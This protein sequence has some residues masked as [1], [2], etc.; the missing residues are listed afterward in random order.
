ML[1]LSQ[2]TGRLK[3]QVCSLAYELAATWRWPTFVQMTQSELSHI[4]HAVDSTINIVLGISI[5]NVSCRD[6]TREAKWNLVL[7]LACCSFAF[8]SSS[9]PSWRQSASG[10]MSDGAL[11]P[12]TLDVYA[13]C[14]D[15]KYRNPG[16]IHTYF[17]KCSLLSLRCFT[18]S[19]VFHRM[20]AEKN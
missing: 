13:R 14:H 1:G 11:L 19:S 7:S 9:T 10:T 12:R 18:Y 5:F 8:D 3:G 17:A 20:T 6:V 16:G 4:A 15:F 2:P